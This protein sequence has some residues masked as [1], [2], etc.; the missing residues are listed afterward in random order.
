[1]SQIIIISGKQ[2]SGKDT[3]AKILLQKLQGFTRVGIGDAIKIEYGKK[4]NLTIDE[5]E[6]NKHLYRAG[7]IAL[8]NSG[9]EQNPDF[10]LEKLSNM[11]KII[12]PDIRVEHEIDFF[13]KRGAFL[14]RVESDVS[15]RSSRGI[16][17]NA[18]DLTETALDNYKNWDVIVENNSGYDDLVLSA[19]SV[20]RKFLA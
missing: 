16:L 18:D 3:L 2:Y 11:N 8:G 9:R 6:N 4:H 19:D 12:V 14:V 10:W 20:V 5:I 13:K 1:M 15:V 17:A 7:L